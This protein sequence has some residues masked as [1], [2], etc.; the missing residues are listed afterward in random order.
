MALQYSGNVGTGIYFP[1]PGAISICGNSNC[2]GIKYGGMAI[3]SVESAGFASGTPAQNL[4]SSAN[5]PGLPVDQYG[6]PYLQM[7]SGDTLQAT[8]A[9]ALTSSDLINFVSSCSDF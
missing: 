5:W 8:F 6:N 4:L 7:V 2:A 9:T 1:V 3:T